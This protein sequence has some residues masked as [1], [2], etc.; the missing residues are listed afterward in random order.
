MIKRIS[1]IGI[2]TSHKRIGMICSFQGLSLTTQCFVTPSAVA[3]TAAL[4]GSKG[5]RERSNEQ[6]QS[7]PDRQLHGIFT[8]GVEVGFHL[9]GY[10][11][12]SFLSIRL[13][14][15]GTG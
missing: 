4:G 12:H 9:C 3:N 14:Q 5:C 6:R 7:E 8:G 2:P 10:F 1:G 13:A 15:A 11:R